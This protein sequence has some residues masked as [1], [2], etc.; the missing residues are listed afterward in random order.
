MRSS[1]KKLLRSLVLLANKIWPL[2][3]LNRFIYKIALWSFLIEARHFPQIISIF[4]KG[5]MLKSDWVPGISDIDLTLIVQEGSDTQE[6]EFLEHFLKRYQSLK[7][8]FPMLG[9]VEMLDKQSFLRW[10]KFSIRGYESR[11]WK[12]L[13]GES[14]PV[15]YQVN[16]LNLQKEYLNHAFFSYKYMFRRA[17]RENDNLWKLRRQAYKI[18]KSINPCCQRKDLDSDI[19]SVLMT[20]ILIELEGG[21]KKIYPRSLYSGSSNPIE[22]SV[23]C[24]D[25]IQ[26][27]DACLSHIESIVHLPFQATGELKDL[28]FLFLLKEDLSFTD[29]QKTIATVYSL[30][31]EPHKIIVLLPSTLAYLRYQDPLFYRDFLRK[32]FVT[33]GKNEFSRE[34]FYELYLTK[35]VIRKFSLTFTTLRSKT[36]LTSLEENNFI[37]TKFLLHILKDKLF[38]ETKETVADENALLKKYQ[39][40]Y[41]KLY[42][43][44]MKLAKDGNKAAK[45]GLLKR[46]MNESGEYLDRQNVYSVFWDV[47]IA[48][49]Y[50]KQVAV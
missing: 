32:G 39:E 16:T 23:S 18:L 40:N 45:L 34:C 50:K 9:E 29:I 11:F 48:D 13:Y 7:S 41:P 36:V 15:S 28:E 43:E 22:T 21:I 4:L 33:Y 17:S 6:L 31:T 2:F 26:E 37:H 42:K 8:I 46:L 47:D 30:K 1:H 25:L 19:P 5:G 38:L 10:S 14:M 24:K 44:I 49:F 3:L 12:L 27:L 20:K 35:D